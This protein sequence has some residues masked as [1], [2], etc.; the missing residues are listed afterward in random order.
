[1]DGTT[2]R[3]V[4]DQLT[5]VDFGRLGDFAGRLD[6]TELAEVNTALRLVLELI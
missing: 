1:M 2:T 3:V 4:I 5:C 6:P